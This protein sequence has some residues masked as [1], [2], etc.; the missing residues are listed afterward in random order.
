[1]FLNK[2]QCKGSIGRQLASTRSI[3]AK[4]YWSFPFLLGFHSGFK[5]H[6]WY[7]L[8]EAV[9]AHSMSKKSRGEWKMAIEAFARASPSHQGKFL[10]FR[11]SSFLEDLGC[12]IAITRVDDGQRWLELFQSFSLLVMAWNYHDP[13]LG[14]GQ[15]VWPA[16][17]LT[18]TKVF[19]NS[20]M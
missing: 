13:L 14:F 2:D 16:A 17:D 6:L 4:S 9:C 15:V 12:S 18:R 7:S 5:T 3:A 20:M 10:G 11:F 19:H 8:F 1:M